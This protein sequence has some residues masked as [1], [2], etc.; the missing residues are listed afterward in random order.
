MLS[1][2]VVQVS[3]NSTLD[4]V[5]AVFSTDAADVFGVWEYPFAGAI[6][7]ANV[8]FDLKGVGNSDGI[9]WS[10]ARA[11]FFIAAGAGTGEA[12]GYGVYADTLAMGSY[13]FGVPGQAQFIFNTS[14]LVCYIVL[15]REP[16]DFKS[17]LKE[18]TALSARISMPPDSAYGPTFWSDDFEQD[19]H[20]AVSNA[21]ENIYDV[22]NHLYY[23]EI[24]AT[25]MFADRP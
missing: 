9:N 3:V 2:T 7:N 6:T 11:P 25:S 13:D 21:Q 23:N 15:P 24:H 18:Y 1:P 22:V 12:G 16:G 10:N 20:G 19:F 17:V 5:G 4:F 14:S 8:S